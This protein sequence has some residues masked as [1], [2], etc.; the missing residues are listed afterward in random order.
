M[1][2]LV[3]VCMGLMYF[4]DWTHIQVCISV[5]QVTGSYSLVEYMKYRI[6]GFFRGGKFSRISHHENFPREIFIYNF[7]KVVR[8]FEY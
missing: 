8:Y 7:I 2:S 4:M 1:G 6:A 3:H 5:K